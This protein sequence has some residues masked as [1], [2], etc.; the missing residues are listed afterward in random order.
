[1]MKYQTLLEISHHN[2]KWTTLN[3]VAK[4]LLTEKD[5]LVFKVQ[6]I[7]ETIIRANQTL[8]AVS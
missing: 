8:Q 7:Q 6:P 3:K 5:W 1:M 2:Y 4:R